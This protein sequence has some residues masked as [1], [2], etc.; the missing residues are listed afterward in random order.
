MI[1]KNFFPRYSGAAV[2]AVRLSK[3]LTKHDV[4][5]DFLVNDNSESKDT[6]DGFNV[7]RIPLGINN[8]VKNFIHLYRPIRFLFKNRRYYDIVHV[9]GPYS[10][11]VIYAFL[12]RVFGMKIVFKNTLLGWDTIDGVSKINFGKILKVFYKKADAVVCMTSGQY[13]RNLEGGIKNDKLYIIPNGVDLIRFDRKNSKVLY[14]RKLGLENDKI[15]GIYVGAFNPRKGVDIIIDV[16][17]ILRK[18]NLNISFILVGP[19]DDNNYFKKITMRIEKYKLTDDIIIIN[20]FEDV[21]DWLLSAD[22]FIFPSYNEGFGTVIIEAMAAGLPVIVNKIEGVT[23]DIIKDKIGIL[24]E[25]NNVEMY[26]NSIIDIINS[27]DIID[28]KKMS[29]YVRDNYDIKNIANKY[30]KMYKKILL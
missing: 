29:K 4:I 15:Y 7:Y 21:A 9:H 17:L 28:L 24:V 5:I 26:V 8:K 16:A 23:T 12:A 30:L 27:K 11:L 6:Y 1:I 25:N 18:R 20:K 14:R 19:I 10:M 22:F 2:Q 13:K 3:E